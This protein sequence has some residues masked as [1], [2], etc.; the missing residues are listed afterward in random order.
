MGVLE[1]SAYL[2]SFTDSDVG[3]LA[4]LQ[5]CTL[6]LDELPAR[7]PAIRFLSESLGG[8]CRTGPPPDLA[9][10]AMA[11]ERRLFGRSGAVVL[12]ADFPDRIGVTTRD[13][14]DGWSHSLGQ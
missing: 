10:R 13:R 14:T 3:V 2:A 11:L 1:L 7:G 9:G 5:A 6:P 4:A 8:L 12:S